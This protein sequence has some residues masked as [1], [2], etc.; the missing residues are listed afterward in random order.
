[1]QTDLHKYKTPM[2]YWLPETASKKKTRMLIT[3][4]LFSIFPVLSL[5]LI[6]SIGI[7]HARHQKG[8][9]Y[10]FLFLGILTYDTLALILQP[11]LSFYTIP[12]LVIGWIAAT[13]IIYRKYIVSKF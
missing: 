6:A 11:V 10:L 13:Y 3:D 5:F 9:V 4:I 1:M 8:K 7:V 2:E 12:V